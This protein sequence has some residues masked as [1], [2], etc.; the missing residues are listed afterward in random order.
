MQL[1]F[2]R[3]Y[4]IMVILTQD[5]S[6]TEVKPWVFNYLRVLRKFNGSDISVIGR[7]KHSL[8]YPIKN[9]V[10]GNYIQLNFWIKSKYLFN[11]LNILKLDSHVLRFATFGNKDKK[12]T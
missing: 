1:I 8:A 4:E 11:I 10:K 5:F 12:L 7:G 9:R 3:A 2:E 6:D